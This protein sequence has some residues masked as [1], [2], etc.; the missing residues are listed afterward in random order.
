MQRQRPRHKLHFVNN[1]VYRSLIDRWLLGVFVGTTVVVVAAFL[2]MLITGFS[3]TSLVMVP[4]LASAVILPWWL[5]ATTDYTL[6]NHSIEVRSG[7]FRWSVPYRDITRIEA[8]RSPLSSPALSL[9]RL[10]I[11]YSGGSQIMI[12]PENRAAF[13]RDLRSRGVSVEVR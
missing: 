9:D 1:S 4:V 12:S 5:V 11:Q 8:T 6:T 2:A 13:V 10:R 3:A 7:P